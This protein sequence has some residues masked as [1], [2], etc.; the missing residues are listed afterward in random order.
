M[1]SRQS[2][3][4][5]IHSY[6]PSFIGSAELDG[7][8]GFVQGLF[9]SGTDNGGAKS[10]TTSQR[11]A[12]AHGVRRRKW[13]YFSY[14]FPF[15]K[16]IAQYQWSWFQGDL[17]A[18]L[19][20]ASFYI[21]MSLSYASNLG[22][23]PPIN[24]MYAFVFNPLIYAFLGSCPQMVVGPEAPGSLLVGTVVRTCIDQSGSDDDNGVLNAEVAGVVTTIA[25]AVIFIAGLARLGFLDSVLSRPF[26][27]GFI[28]AIGIV[29]MVDQAI[30]ELGLTKLADKEVSHSSTAQKFVFLVTSIGKSHGLTAAVSLSAFAVI[31]VLREMKNR[32]QP[33][34]PKV[35]YIP[36]RFIVVA[37]S[38]ILT[39]KFGWDKQGLEV[40][41]EVK[42]S[43]G[44]GIPFHWPFQFRHMKH[45]DTA[46]STAFLIALLGFFE[47]TVAAKSLAAGTSGLRG[48]HISANRELVA[49][50]TAN[51]IGGCFMALPAFGGYGRSKV[52]KSTGGTTPM[53]SILLSLITLICVFYV[54]P[55]FYYLPKGVLSAM[56]SVVAY[57]LVEECP[58]DIK[59]FVKI[60]GWTELSLMAIIFFATIFYNLSTGIALGI[61]LSLLQ[62]IRHATKPRIQILGKV[63]G[64]T[65]QFENAEYFPDAIEFVEGSLI[66]KIPEPLT[67]ANTGELKNRLRRLEKYGTERAHP[68]LPRLRQEESNKN[69]I[70]DV[71]GVTSIDG[72]GTQVLFEIVQDYVNGGARV[73]F[74]R[75]PKKRSK[76]F[77]AFRRSGIIELCGGDRHFVDN[78]EEALKLSEIE[79][80]EQYFEE[81]ADGHQG[82][83]TATSW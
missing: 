12:R 37:L 21:P 8:G 34:Y 18:A 13:M 14:Y 79:D 30:P 22:H 53:S 46:L 5:N 51:L 44:H 64:T 60:R 35:A 2:S 38:A 19:T 36:D 31:M 48:M 10:L 70:F 52:N 57:S 42:S 62:L 76:V 59:F 68:S 9:S 65:N 74:C 50:G 4:D 72:S 45:I 7:P 26:L 55:W 29:I 27:R 81:Q 78:V 41:G 33:R 39:W 23:I 40:L 67:F 56:V 77:E 16:W 17:V 15:V 24:G 80:L 82:R 43:E 83:D 54:V 73:I 32:L 49:L 1:H 47:S 28:S 66:V 69:I 6:E 11:L 71:H 3:M 75:L 58:H 63:H 25:G 20:M 61:G